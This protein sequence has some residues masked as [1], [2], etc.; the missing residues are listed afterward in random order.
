MTVLGHIA[1]RIEMAQFLASADAV[2]APGPIETFGLAAL[3]SLAC[4][5]PVLCNEASAIP[6]VLGPDAGFVRPL[7]PELWADCIETSINDAAD[8]RAR[9]RR[10]AEE[11]PWSRTA[12][13]LLRV[14]GITATT[15]SNAPVIVGSLEV[16]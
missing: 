7:D 14:S 11:F 5:T 1:S 12:T 10:R 6:E 4:G 15:A 13:S 8:V 9:A 16:G 2:L 3:E